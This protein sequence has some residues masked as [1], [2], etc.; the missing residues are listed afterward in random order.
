MGK[1]GI[2]ANHR[3]DEKLG[4]LID[5]YNPIGNNDNNTPT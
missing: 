4:C 2:K 5:L 3:L 1:N